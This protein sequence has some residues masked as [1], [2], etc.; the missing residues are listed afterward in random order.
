MKV[1]LFPFQKRA[2]SELRMKIGEA[3]GG[4][5]R[6]HSNQ[7]VSFTAPTGAGKTIIMASLIESVFFG[8]VDYPEQSD[9]IIVWLSDSPQL[10]EQSKLK[11]DLK[12]DRIRIGQ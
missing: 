11:I 12:A 5:Q 9:A 6:T 1:E 4:Y 10:N 8:D 7:V 3:V 2:L